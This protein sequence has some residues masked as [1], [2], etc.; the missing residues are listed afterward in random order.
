MIEV[1]TKATVPVTPELLARWFWNMDSNEQIQVF[2]HLYDEIQKTNKDRPILGEYGDGQWHH[3]RWS[4]E[5]M[6]QPC[7]LKAIN[8]LRAI[9]A[10]F[11]LYTV[12][13]DWERWPH[14]VPHTTMYEEG[15]Q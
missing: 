3:L 2:S 1:T 8:T 5:R 7:Q 15:V 6:P 12:G 10:P 11:F 4:A 14:D 13:L 9:A